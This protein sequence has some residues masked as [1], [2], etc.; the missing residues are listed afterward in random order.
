[1]ISNEE[2]EER[3]YGMRQQLKAW[4]NFLEKKY[5][6]E[7]LSRCQG[8]AI[9]HYLFSRLIKDI[10]NQSESKIGGVHVPI[11][12]IPP[13]SINNDEVS[14]NEFIL[15]LKNEFKILLSIEPNNLAD[16]ED[17]TDQMFNRLRTRF[18]F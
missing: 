12:L 6:Y 1:M 11:D 18:S 4:I 8:L 10:K 15:F 2:L 14:K 17:F 13:T 5:Q 9:K 7:S 3:Y 16:L